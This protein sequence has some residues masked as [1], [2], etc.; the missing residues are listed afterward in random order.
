V[1]RMQVPPGGEFT[2][3]SGL[4]FV[5]ARLRPHGVGINFQRKLWVW[6]QG[7]A[8]DCAC[9]LGLPPDDSAAETLQGCH[10]EPAPSSGNGAASVPGEDCGS[11][12]Q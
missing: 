11:N 12:P 4:G 8:R 3:G 7:H 2:P 1:L 5:T 6:E 9:D 10:A